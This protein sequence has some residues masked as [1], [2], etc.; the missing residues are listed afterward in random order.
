M[1]ECYDSSWR[2]TLL[3][4]VQQ[5]GGAMIYHTARCACRPKEKRIEKHA[6]TRVHPCT[7]P[8]KGKRSK[9]TTR[10]ATKDTVLKILKHATNH[11]TA[12]IHMRRYQRYRRSRRRKRRKPAS[13][14]PRTCTHSRDTDDR[15]DTTRKLAN[16]TTLPTPHAREVVRNHTESKPIATA[17]RVRQRDHT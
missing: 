11:R 13:T 6:V 16:E 4:D 2:V 15:E 9:H 3:T 1:E 7:R 10:E 14:Q 12:N 5:T 8:R 17:T